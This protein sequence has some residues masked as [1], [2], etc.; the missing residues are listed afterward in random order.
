L[1]IKATQHRHDAERSA[2]RDQ[3]Y[4]VGFVPRVTKETPHAEGDTVTGDDFYRKARRSPDSPWRRP[5]RCSAR[6]PP[7]TMHC[8]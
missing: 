4:A 6:R 7:L 3:D 5:A 8:L 2:N 1:I